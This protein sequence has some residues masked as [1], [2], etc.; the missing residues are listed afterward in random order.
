M[1]E[2]LSDTSRSHVESMIKAGMGAVCSSMHMRVSGVEGK[3]E[4][5]QVSTASLE[6]QL[7]SALGRLEKLER[8]HNDLREDFSRRM[9]DAE[10]RL[11]LID[12]RLDKL[13]VPAAGAEGG[14]GVESTAR[15]SP[16][17]CN[18]D[19]PYELRTCAK[20]GGFVFDTVRDVLL[21]EAKRCLQDA[22][23]D[24]SEWKW[25][26]SPNM[27]GS[28]VLLTFNTAGSLQR[29]RQ[30]VNASNFSHGGKRIWLDTAK[31]RAELLPA[32]NTHRCYTALVAE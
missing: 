29:A 16:P 20:I 6:V 9:G 23:I 22:G 17:N 24:D 19:T 10:K 3:V 8:E 13:V 32:R 7:Q 5:V 11:G 2:G 4:G 18:S 21:A 30:A 26:H 28:W 31:T 27:K 12:E 25:M 1:T 15:Q 14:S